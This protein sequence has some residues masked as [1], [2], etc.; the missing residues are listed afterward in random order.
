MVISED[1]VVGAATTIESVMQDSMGDDLE[2][3]NDEG[4]ALDDGTG[5]TNRRQRN[6]G[7]APARVPGNEI[8]TRGCG[9]DNASA[10]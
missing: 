7:P 5:M 4:P 8:S 9:F 6:L 3:H 2:G 10:A 1:D